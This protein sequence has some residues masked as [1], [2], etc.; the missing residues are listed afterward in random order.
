MNQ[1][2]MRIAVGALCATLAACSA[3][4]GER[5]PGDLG[6]GPG[7]SGTAGTTAAPGGA[8]TAGVPGSGR[9]LAIVRRICERAGWR[10]DVLARSPGVCFRL[11]VPASSRNPHADLTLP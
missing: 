1:R 3:E 7:T 2:R 9:G 6:T 4:S 8:G 11:R 10:V 5:S